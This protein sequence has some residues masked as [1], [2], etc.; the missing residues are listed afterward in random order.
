[1]KQVCRLL[2][3]CLSV[4][5]LMASCTEEE[6]TL[7]GNIQGIVTESGTTTP[8]NGVQ[9]NIIGLGTST[10][11][12]SD[13]QFSFHDLDADSYSL[14]FM[15]EGYVTNTRGIT[16]LVGETA[17]CDIQLEPEQQDAEIAI[18]PST[19]DFGVT[20]SEMAVTITNNGNAATEWS[21]NLG[22]NPWLSASPASGNIAAGR[23]QSIVF[24][25]DRNRLSETK[26]ARVTLAAFGNSYTISVS[27][28]PRTQAAEMTV[29]P[30]VL[31][32]GTELSELSLDIRNT[33]NA[34][35]NYSISKLAADY[36]TVLPMSGTVAG[37]GN[38]VV[39]VR[40]DRE[41]IPSAVV[42]TTFVISDG[43]KE[44]A[45]S[46]TASRTESG[47]DEPVS[48]ETVMPQGLYTYY[49]FDGT[50]ED[51]TENAV[52]GFGNC[53]FVDGVSGGQAL[54]FSRTDNTTFTVGKPI[55]D[56]RE[57]TFSF[58]G[59]NFADGHIFHL[60][61]SN[62]NEPMFTLSMDGGA[63][64]FVITRYNNRYQYE[65]ATPFVHPTLTDGQWHHI[66]IVS[67]FEVTA[68]ST[69]THTLYVDGL[70][71]ST[72]TESA[73]HFNENGGSQSSYDTGTTFIMG[74]SLKLSNS[75]NLN[76]TNMLVDNFRVYDNR[77]LSANEIEKIYAAKQ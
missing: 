37:G 57:M 49:K 10:V 67:D 2:G 45:I 66:A 24:S 3:V 32:F 31:D 69:V 22:E 62:G 44:T 8:L 28:S 15:K 71:V 16:V 5:L 48:G 23:T 6:R 11:T 42:N 72:V 55:V 13:G 43:I 76:A 52:H 17:N 1:M 18:E 9:V 73:N 21:L 20:Q 14:Q 65:A 7:Y 70:R 34:E 68:Y 75:V 77:M 12:G 46:V 19:L 40:L 36:L 53:T 59:K 27:C 39:Q 25:V 26:T 51:A 30:T 58:W 60:L 50:Y 54:K 63:L 29:S 47:D 4:V 64:K 33:G 61:S 38:Q 74:G 35:L 56:S 41:L